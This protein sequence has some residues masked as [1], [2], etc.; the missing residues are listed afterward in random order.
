MRVKHFKLQYSQNFLKD[1]LLVNKLIN[2]SGIKTGDLVLEIGPGKGI[3]TQALSDYG[4]H[5][6]AVEKDENLYQL[7][8]QKFTNY[9]NTQ[10]VLGDFLAYYLPGRPYKVFANIPF[11]LTTKIIN[12]LL[13][14]TNP[15]QESYLIIQEEAAKKLAGQPY[16]EKRLKSLWFKPWFEFSI[17]YNF[18]ST[19]FTPVPAV[20]IVLFYIKRRVKSLIAVDKQ[21]QY[22]D[23]IVYGFSQVKKTLQQSLKRI[24]T[25]EQFL[26]LA[27]DLK[28]NLGVTPS[29]LTFEQWLGLF[30]FF[31]SR[32]ESNKQKIIN[33]SAERLLQQQKTLEKNYRTRKY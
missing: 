21:K 1:R 3:I 10:I 12:K 28:F 25:N 7:L 14:S 29:S 16:G 4:C 17:I 30:E 2:Q 31:N 22:Y 9:P 26:R 18:C 8:K 27:K 19:D 13:Q 32:I 33:S 20:K 23:F 6:L 11:N 5:V 24:F 15:P